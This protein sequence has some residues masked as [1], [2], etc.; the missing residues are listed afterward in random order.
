MQGIGVRGASCHALENI[1]RLVGIAAAACTAFHR[2]RH[3]AEDE[4]QFAEVA[5]FSS[6]LFPIF[7]FKKV[8]CSSL[9]GFR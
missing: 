4:L 2:L 8:I 9:Q 1:P 7:L 3:I 6:Y 5:D